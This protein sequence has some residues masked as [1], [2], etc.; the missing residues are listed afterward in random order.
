MQ[1]KKFLVYKLLVYNCI[2]SCMLD[3]GRVMLSSRAVYSG[4]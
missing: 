2:A 4:R 3:R 1:S